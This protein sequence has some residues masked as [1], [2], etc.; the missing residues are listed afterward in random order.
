MIQRW[1]RLH[2]CSGV[3]YY[4]TGKLAY[5]TFSQAFEVTLPFPLVT[6]Q[7]GGDM[8]G[9]PRVPAKA[10]RKLGLQDASSKKPSPTPRHPE[11]S[12]YLLNRSHSM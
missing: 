12:I 10:S 4:L 9:L 5:E 2:P 1:P 11:P 8:K 7:V 3:P 6:E